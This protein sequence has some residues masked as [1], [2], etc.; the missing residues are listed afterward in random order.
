M[1]S[2]W[3]FFNRRYNIYIYIYVDIAAETEKTPDTI[4]Q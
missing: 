1:L 2:V 3:R 4:I